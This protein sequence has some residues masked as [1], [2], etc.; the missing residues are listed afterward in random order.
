M[1]GST[2]GHVPWN[3][4]T[5][6]EADP[7]CTFDTCLTILA[8]CPLLSRAKFTC[9]ADPDWA[10]TPFT[11]L[12]QYLTL[13]AL[14]DLSIKASRI[15][16]TPFF[17]RLALPALRSLALEYCQVPRAKSNHQS[18]YSLLERSSCALAA[19]SLHETAR[20]RD[21]CHISYLQ[22]PHMA[23]V[24]DLELKVDMTNKIIEFFSYGAADGAPQL[25]NL[26]EIALRDC[27]GDHISE[28]A[29]TQMLLSRLAPS[30]SP[31]SIPATLRLAD[32]QL[33]MAG[34]A[35]PVLTMDGR[36]H[37]LEFRFELLN[38]FCK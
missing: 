9:S 24:P 38:C 33:R 17:N 31:P 26:T 1:P 36:V 8:S 18:L 15:D 11:H 34:H 16:L 4:L 12:D 30:N 2:E 32:I 10:H 27:R 35:E 37:N 14:V 13:P 28:D 6:L 3:R 19:F 25:P 20:R 21:R 29:L 22:S 5:H 7:E 23:S